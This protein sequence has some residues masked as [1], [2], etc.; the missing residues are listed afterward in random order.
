MSL[1]KFIIK[2]IFMF[3]LTFAIYS[4][5][6]KNKTIFAHLTQH[7]GPHATKIHKQIQ[8]QLKISFQTSKDVGEQLFYNSAPPK[9]LEV[10]KIKLIQAAPKKTKD[11]STMDEID[12][13]DKEKLRSILN[14]N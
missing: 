14:S 10:E 5:P 11:E 4:Y 12:F 2:T 6:Y 13:E 9:A 3:I 8:E 7:F 1:I